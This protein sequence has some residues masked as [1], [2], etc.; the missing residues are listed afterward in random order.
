MATN[1]DGVWSPTI[2]SIPIIVSPP[3]WLTTTAKLVYTLL[4]LVAFIL[5]YIYTKHWLQLRKFYLKQFVESQ[6]NYIQNLR[7]QFSTNISHELR[8]PLTLII[9]Q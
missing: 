8:T 2:Y 1:N 5:I 9:Q 6:T 4:C 3:W 7:Q